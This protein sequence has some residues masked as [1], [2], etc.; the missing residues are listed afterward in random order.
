[1]SATSDRNVAIYSIL[2]DGTEIDETLSK[3]IREIKILSYL[4]LPDTCTLVVVYEKGQEG[5]DQPIDSHPFDIG[6]SLEVKLGARDELTT[7]SLFK[8]QIVSLEL[9]FGAGGVELLV[10]GFDRSHALI[11]ARKVRTFQNKTTSDIVTKVLSDAGFSA[12]CDTTGDPHDFM[13]QDN[14]TDWDFIWRLAER[15][16]FEFVVEDN[17]AHFRKPTPTTRW[18]SSGRRRCARSAHA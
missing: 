6:K 9:N 12:D 3:S 7:T 18:S 10:R 15:V 2:I 13:Q 8:G 17:D 1:M 11:R 5:E 16:G 14:E 4:R